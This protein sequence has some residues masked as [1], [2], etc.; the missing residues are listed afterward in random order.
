MFIWDQFMLVSGHREPHPFHVRSSQIPPIQPLVALE[1]YLED[2]KTQQLP[3]FTCCPTRCLPGFCTGVARIHGIN[4]LV[5]TFM[6]VQLYL[7]VSKFI[8]QSADLLLEDEKYSSRTYQKASFPVVPEQKIYFR[9]ILLFISEENKT[10]INAISFSKHDVLK[11]VVQSVRD[12]FFFY[13]PCKLKDYLKC[14]L[15]KFM[16]PRK[17]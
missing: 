14:R 16:K 17:S 1:S 10:V 3:H 12:Y 5:I 2:A 9:K 15:F 7:C 8:S 4:S 11:P 13:R 6:G